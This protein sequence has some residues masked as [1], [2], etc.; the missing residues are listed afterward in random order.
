[1]KRAIIAPALPAPEALA[2]LKQWL[3]ITTSRDDPALA[4]TIA[5][6]LELFEGFTGLMPLEATCEEVLPACGGWRALATR[7]VQA[8]VGMEAVAPDG[9]RNALPA[10]SYEIELD[11]ENGARVRAPGLS[12]AVAVRFVAGLAPGWAEL[13]ESLRHGIIRCAAHL[14]RAREGAGSEALPPAAVT[15]LWR[16]WRR[17]RLA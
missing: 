5:A 10:G 8:I 16:P 13:P 7:P 14:F 1:M 17:M 15:A 12:G 9:T 11:A 6:A 3:A 2:E 4:A